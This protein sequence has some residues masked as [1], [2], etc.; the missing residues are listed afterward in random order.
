MREFN[1]PGARVSGKKVDRLQHVFF[2]F[3]A[4][5]SLYTDRY[6]HR[7]AYA[8][9]GLHT[10]LDQESTQLMRTHMRKNT[11]KTPKIFSINQ[12]LLLTLW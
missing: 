10:A 8:S 9:F 3:E 11:I 1:T 4:V 2:T 5:V 7:E 6:T 12:R